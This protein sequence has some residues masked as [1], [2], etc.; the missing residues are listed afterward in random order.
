MIQ[1]VIKDMKAF[2]FVLSVAIIGFANAFYI[3]SRNIGLQMNDDGEMVSF[4]ELST[5]A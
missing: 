5:D 3:L 2:G 4:F 1:E